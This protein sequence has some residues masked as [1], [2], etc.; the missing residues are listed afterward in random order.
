MQT[1]FKIVGV[2]LKQPTEVD[3]SYEV[4]DKAERTMDGTMVVDIIGRK[5]RLE[6]N[7]A[8]LDKEDMKRLGTAVKSGQFVT[9]QFNAPDTGVLTTM[10][11]RPNDF[12]YTPQ[13]D[14]VHDE[15]MWKSVH[16]KFVER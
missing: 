2:T 5:R 10:V 6:V 9:V 11:A 1:F 8:Y 13:Y 15:L 14:W 3:Y 4:L 12:A 16:V 7:W